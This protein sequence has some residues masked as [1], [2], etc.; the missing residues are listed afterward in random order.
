LNFIVAPVADASKPQPFAGWWQAPLAV[1]R[2]MSSAR[3]FFRFQTTAFD[4]EKQWRKNTAKKS[5]PAVS[6]QRMHA[7]K[8][9]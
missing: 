3:G 8:N 5:G 4:H 6:Q 9:L 1:A 7:R 2:R